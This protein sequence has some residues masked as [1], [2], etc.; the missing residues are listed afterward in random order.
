M[1]Y[2]VTELIESY[3]LLFQRTWG[4]YLTLILTAMFLPLDMYELVDHFTWLKMGFTIANALV[5]WY[6]AW[7]ILKNRRLRAAAP[8]T[9]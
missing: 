9:P 3:G 2:G 5:V 7:L 6:L 8:P 4:E 1:V